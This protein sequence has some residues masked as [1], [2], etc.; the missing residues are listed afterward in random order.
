MMKW[1][2]HK[3]RLFAENEMPIIAYEKIEITRIGRERHL[4]VNGIV[5]LLQYGSQEMI[6]ALKHGQLTIRG[7]DLNCTTYISGAMGVRG[8]VDELIFARDEK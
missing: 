8:I 1:R 5:H 7:K 4:I 6:L 3:K 2:S